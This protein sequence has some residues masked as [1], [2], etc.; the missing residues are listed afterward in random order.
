M[1]NDIQ[2]QIL[3]AVLLVMRPIARALLRAGIGYLEFA[4]ISKTAFVDVAGKDYGLRGRPTN[5][6]RVAVMT[7]L[8]R[9]EVRRIRDKAKVGDEIGLVKLTPMG[10]VMHRWFTEDRFLAENGSPKVLP[11]EG[12]GE[13][14]SGLVKSYGG[15]IPPGAMRTE[16]KRIGAVEELES[17]QLSAAKRSVVGIE[18]H[19]KLIS[20]L[21]HVLYPAALAMAHN[22][23]A[24]TETDSWVHL[25]A[26]TESVR[27]QDLRRIRRVST[28]R[29]AAFIE[30]VDD[31]LAAYETLY[32]SDSTDESTKAV[33]IGVFY[34]EED[35]SETDVFQ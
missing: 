28:D 18:D 24:G 23:A 32:D 34:F 10:K 15:D 8:T 21:A 2:R 7:G 26:S 17:G 20:G 3:G 25:S 14:F 12:E 27:G 1:Q 11:F 16:L 31:F 19:E 30:S 9:K 35:K 22:T 4:E 6:S 33:G 29:A 13:T 5:I